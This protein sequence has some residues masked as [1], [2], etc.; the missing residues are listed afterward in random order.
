MPDIQKTIIPRFPG[1]LWF[2]GDV[3][4]QYFYLFTLYLLIKILVNHFMKR[5]HQTCSLG[6]PTAS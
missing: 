1:S 2:S 5:L 4:V 6:R 3:T